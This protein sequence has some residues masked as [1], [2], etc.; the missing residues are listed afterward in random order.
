[1]AASLPDDVLRDILLRLND[2]ATLF[3]CATACWRWRTLVT[4]PTFLRHRWP[5][6]SCPSLAGFLIKNPGRDQGGKV[7]VPAPQSAL[8]RRCRALSSFVPTVPHS[9]PLASRRGLLLVRLVPP[10]E[11]DLD[12]TVLHLA[13]C[14]LLL[15][16]C[17]TLPP[18]VCS[19]VGYSDYGCHCCAVLSD[20]DC[21]SSD[22]ERPPGN[23]SFYKVLIVTSGHESQLK[24][25]VHT[26]SSNIPSWST[27][28]SRATVGANTLGSFCQTDAVV[29]RDERGHVFT[30]DLKTRAMK[31]VAD[32]P[33]GRHNSPLDAVLLEMDWPAFFV[34]RLG[35]MSGEADARRRRHRMGRG[36][37]KIADRGK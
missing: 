22:D 1:M 8:G 35:I 3:R 6:N 10:R 26:L 19:S 23:S 17:D 33:H 21:R 15:G 14:N 5:E 4:N 20:D 7:L 9:V 36:V 12:Q 31:E 18:L 28:R 25:D 16:T 13:V 37:R 34:S 11:A 2:A 29:C 32:R 24:F 30:A 27:K